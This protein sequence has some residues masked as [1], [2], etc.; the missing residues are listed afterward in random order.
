[1]EQV[2]NIPKNEEKNAALLKLLRLPEFAELMRTDSNP[3][4]KT[5]TAEPALQPRLANHEGK[6]L[7][8][9]PSTI[10]KT[11]QSTSAK[12]NQNINQKADPTTTNKSF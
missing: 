12:I 10:V 2:F 4:P 5:Y 9:S 3:T 1:M 8:E 11:A 7:P 6:I